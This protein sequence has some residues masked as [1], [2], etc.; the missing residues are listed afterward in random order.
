M[1]ERRALWRCHLPQG[2]PLAD[3]VNLA[4]MAGL[5]PIVGGLIRNAAVAAGFL[6]ASD[7]GE[8]A[9]ITR[10]HL[11]RAVRREYEKSGRAFPG[12]PAGMTDSL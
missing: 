5:Y 1:P 12:V 7:G 11:V 9:T 3:D 4:E 6:A 10:S 2:V 8:Q